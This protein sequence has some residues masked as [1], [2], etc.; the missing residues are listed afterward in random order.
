MAK[1]LVSGGAGYIGSHVVNLLGQAGH[2][3][4]VYDNLSSGFADSVLCGRLVEGDLLDLAALRKLFQEEKFAAVIHF[5]AKIVVS[6]SVAEPIKYYRNNVAGTLNLL[7]AMQ[8]AGVDKLIFSSTAAVY[9]SSEDGEPLTEDKELAPIN[10]YG[11]SKKM[12]EKILADL[13]CASD[14]R[15]V[16]LRYF[17]VAGA[18]VSGLIGEKKPDATHLITMSVRAA[19]GLRDKLAIYG[20]DYPTPDGTCIRDYIHVEDLAKAHVLA[21]DYLLKGGRS[22]TFNCGYGRG[23]SVKEVV[24]AVKR[25]TG[26]DFP[27]ETAPRRAGDAPKLI[28]DAGKIRK[29]LNWQPK[30][31]D[32]DYIIKTAWQWE[33]KWQSKKLP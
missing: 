15:Y 24:E 31:D 19:L 9:R 27:V 5:A 10:P 1:I 6:E 33:K 16:V 22:E 2:E 23:Y 26:V 29:L 14:F 28:S 11:E 32:L 17:N 30:Y 18:S 3:A 21:L 4:V 20:T 13:S 7:T 25:V 8:E 12:V